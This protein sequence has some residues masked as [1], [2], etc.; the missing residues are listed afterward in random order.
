MPAAD[1]GN[2]SPLPS[3]KIGGDLHAAAAMD[4]AIPAEDQKYVGYGKVQGCLPYPIQ[5]GYHR[6]LRPRAFHVAVLENDILR[7]TFLLELGGRLWSLIHKPMERELLH[8]TPMF[9]PANLAI[10]N[11]W[12][13][14]GVE[15]NVGVV[16]H[17]PFTCSPLFA[18]RVQGPGGTPAL[19][20]YEW[21]RI[22]QAPFQ[23]DSYLPDRSPVLFVRVRIVN[24]HDR[25]IPMS[26][27]SNIAVPETLG[28]RV[29]APADHAYRF[30]YDGGL[31]RADIPLYEG[32]DVTYPAAQKQAM[33]FFYRIP[34]GVRPWIAA[35]DGAGLGL[36]QTSTDLLKGRKL[37][38]WG[39]GPGG[40]RWQEHLSGPGQAY[41]EI[42]AGPARTQLEHLP[43]PAHTEWAWLEAYGLMEAKPSLIHGKDWPQ[44]AATVAGQLDR[45]VNRTA[46]DLELA[47]GAEMAD[48]VPEEIIQQ[49]SGWGALEG[50]RRVKLGQAPFCSPSL[51]FGD[52][53]L[54]DAQTPWLELLRTGTFPCGEADMPP[55]GCVVGPEWRAL[56]EQAAAQ[57]PS[58][59][60]LAWLHLGVMRYHDGDMPGARSAWETSLADR[61]SVWALR[62]LAVLARQEKQIDRSV[63]LYL[64]AVRMQPNCLAL[65]IECGQLLVDAKKP[66]IWIALLA[67]LPKV[68]RAA[69]RVRLM[70]GRAALALDDLET[71]EQLL[72]ES[73]E[74]C[75][76]REGEQ[77]LCDLWF[78]LHERRL[79]LKENLP[80]DDALRARVRREFPPPA[81]IDYRMGP[82]PDQYGP[83]DGA[84]EAI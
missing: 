20:L 64:Q 35:L 69:G 7:A 26:W 63:K 16:G 28:T 53:S 79:S 37:F 48:R 51:V 44:A 74:L 55:A 65:V 32:K 2:D 60:W 75:D 82:E 22:R 77:S 45:L 43:M 33:D 56:L 36:V 11:A 80:V 34:D 4:P 61:L 67:E 54:G 27:W 25:E 38:M 15:W 42:Q 83:N 47:R 40:K 78:G 58:S 12:F 9:Q 13:C 18:A 41:I 57:G 76:M 17:C 62:N 46:L 84:L 21:E 72:M 3:L 29:L 73:P 30:G 59:H 70:E 1:M 81:R 14:G 71:V 19:R 10:R 8:V 23:I 50:K 31:R 49:G 6:E 52:E 5:D 39:T 24:P 68:I 66:A